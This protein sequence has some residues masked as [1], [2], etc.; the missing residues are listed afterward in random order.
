M[1]S[2]FITGTDTEIGKTFSACA[3]MVALS[4]R[5]L[6]VAPM[7]P[8]AAGTVAVQHPAAGTVAVQHPA[9]GTVAVGETPLNEDVRDLV[10]VY[11][12]CYAQVI[13]T[14]IVNP[15]CFAEPIAPHLAARHEGRSVDMRTI[16]SAFAELQSGHDTVFVEGAGGFLVPLDDTTSMA[17]I[18]R[19]LQ[20]DVIVV[21][22]MRLG[23]IN[24]ALLTVEAVRSRGLRVAGWIGNRVD[25]NMLCFDENVATLRL[26]I[27]APCLGIVPR[28]AGDDCVARAHAASQHIDVE[29]L[30]R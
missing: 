24:H 15:Y 22:G 4:A 12:A 20:L 10:Q 27:D 13:N 30:L 25:P 23:C 21:V 11:T 6:R 1:K 9:A 26:L 16:A 2:F 14:T 19:A 3:L 8:L 17:E 5:G 28:I 18:P 7:K 29:P